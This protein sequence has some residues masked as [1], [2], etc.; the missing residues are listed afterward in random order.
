MNN[1]KGTVLVIEDD[2]GITKVVNTLFSINK[3]E[4]LFADSGQQGIEMIRAGG[5]DL[6]LCDIMLPDMAGY[7]ILNEVKSNGE[8]YRLPFL[9]M[10][11]LAD[12]VDVRKGMN[13]GADDYITKPFSAANLIAAV[14]SRLKIKE[15][16]DKL[17]QQAVSEHWQNLLNDNFNHEFM[18]PLNGILNIVEILG[19]DAGAVNIE[20]F[21]RMLNAISSSGLRMHRNIKKLT[22]LS[23]LNA[24]KVVEKTWVGKTPIMELTQSAVVS[25]KKEYAFKRLDLQLSLSASNF[26]SECDEYLSFIITELVDNALKFSSGEGAVIVNLFDEGDH[27]VM[28]ITN[29]SGALQNVDLETLVPFLKFHPDMTMDGLGIGLYICY[30]LCKILSFPISMKCNGSKTTFKLV[31]NNFRR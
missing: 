10:T 17:N 30:Q 15:H 5:I 20:D 23:L 7:D 19:S 26:T 25:I 12:P 31:L 9:F 11:A 3:I 18:T 2:K 24:R 28:E 6:V 14:T 13:L 16:Q 21:K 1:I 27:S 22:L 29:K 4:G 8:T